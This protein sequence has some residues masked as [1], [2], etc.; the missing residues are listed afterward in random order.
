MA[1]GDEGC[2]EFT[3]LTEATGTD[4]SGDSVVNKEDGEMTPED[5]TP[6]MAETSVDPIASEGHQ[7]ETKMATGDKVCLKKQGS[8]EVDITDQEFIW[9]YLGQLITEPALEVN[10]M[11][12]FRDIKD[13]ISIQDGGVVVIDL[14]G[15]H[16]FTVEYHY[17]F[18]DL[19]SAL[20]DSCYIC[21]ADF[22]D[23]K[24]L[25]GLKWG[26]LVSFDIANKQIN[27]FGSVTPAK[28]KIV[29]LNGIAV[30]SGFVFASDHSGK[31][32]SVFDHEGVYLKRLDATSIQPGSLALHVRE[33]A[34]SV[35]VTSGLVVK[36]Y[37]ISGDKKQ[38]KMKQTHHF[39]IDKET[40][41]FKRFKP[42]HISVQEDKLLVVNHLKDP[43]LLQLLQLNVYNGAFMHSIIAKAPG[44]RGVKFI[45]G[46]RIVLYSRDSVHV[47]KKGDAK[48]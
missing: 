47:L 27:N 15:L 16:R 21:V 45:S 22:T 25:F 26:K 33:G 12:G 30:N 4:T 38:T 6:L 1:P 41:E 43:G 24:L 32:I 37:H 11:S 34:Q 29:R 46:D 9:N 20:G 28:D 31:T 7:D 48:Q 39:D 40:L 18:I 17:R 19:Y 8:R 42:G 10:N 2:H 14:N 5:N 3:P 23:G 35:F 44:I 13:V 36:K